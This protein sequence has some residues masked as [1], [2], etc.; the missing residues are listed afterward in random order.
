MILPEVNQ[1]SEYIVTESS[2]LASLNECV[3][4]SSALCIDEGALYI[5]ID[6]QT[7]QKFGSSETVEIS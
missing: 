4:G 5:K 6:A 3:V 2:D 7:W 1:T